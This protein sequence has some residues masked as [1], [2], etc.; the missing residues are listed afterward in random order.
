MSSALR[1]FFALALVMGC[2]PVRSSVTDAAQAESDGGSSGDAG[3]AGCPASPPEIGRACASGP[4]CEWGADSHGQ[5]ATFG[6]CA[7]VQSG[8]NPV[9]NAVVPDAGCGHLGPQ[10]PATFSSL[11]SGS[12]CPAQP[13]TCEYDE[14][15]CECVTCYTSFLPGAMWACRQ[16]TDGVAPDCAQPRPTLN[17]ACTQE[18]LIC[19]YT[20][21]CSDISLGRAISA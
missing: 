8:S 12:A 9:W 4:Y 21:C 17:S 15:V 7:S 5:C 2:G 1:G 16:Y 13:L 14:G 18:G 19:D 11:S 20:P 3:L 10:C 6:L